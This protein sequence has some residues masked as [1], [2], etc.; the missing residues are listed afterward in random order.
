MTWCIYQ[1]SSYTEIDTI[2]IVAAIMSAERAPAEA[3]EM[4]IG[5]ARWL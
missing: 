1:K 2:F 3:S 5:V 4:V